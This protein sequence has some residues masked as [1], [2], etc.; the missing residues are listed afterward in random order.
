MKC[1]LVAMLTIIGG[2]TV[3]A[4]AQ[5]QGSFS[6]GSDLNF[7]GF[8]VP[9]ASLDLQSSSFGFA[10]EYYFNETFGVGAGL[11]T[12]SSSGDGLSVNSTSISISTGVAFANDLDVT[13]GTGQYNTLGIA[14]VLGNSTISGY[15]LTYSGS[16]SAIRIGATGGW[17]PAPS[18]LIFASTATTPISDWELQPFTDWGQS[19]TLGFGYQLIELGMLKVTANVLNE[20]DSY[21]DL[22]SSG[23]GLGV[24]YEYIF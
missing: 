20:Y 18:I 12:A 23:F 17:S 7:L 5:K 10:A 19:S 21:T 3:S 13:A 16:S 8:E 14:M 22:R 9:G 6:V 2:L 4:S 24:G 15:G 11:G 1:I